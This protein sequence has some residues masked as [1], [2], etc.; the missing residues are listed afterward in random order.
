M[1]KGFLQ[2]PTGSQPLPYAWK[3]Y[4]VSFAMSRQAG[5]Y[6]I[7]RVLFNIGFVSIR[8]LSVY[9]TAI[10]RC[11][12]AVVVLAIHDSASWA[13]G[14]IFKKAGKRVPSFTDAN[15]AS[16]VVL[17]LAILWIAATIMHLPPNVVEGL[18]GASEPCLCGATAPTGL[19]VASTQ[20]GFKD[21][22]FSSAIAPTFNSVSC[23]GWV[24]DMWYGINY[25]ETCEAS[26]NGD[27]LTL[28]SVS[29]INVVFQSDPPVTTD[30][31]LAPI[32]LIN[33]IVSI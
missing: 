24:L 12:I 8:S 7:Q 10:V 22:N 5:R 9:P 6:S 30:G 23:R 21:D 28:H 14:H 4:F 29:F 31:S 1:A 11:V 19:A 20:M 13:W 15:S 16:S 17:V 18:V 25:G 27:R 2:R 26:S 3:R 32:I 33:P